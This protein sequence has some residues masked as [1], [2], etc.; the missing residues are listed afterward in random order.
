MA[1]RHSFHYNTAPSIQ[2]VYRLS[3]VIEAVCHPLPLFPLSQVIKV[4]VLAVEP[5]TGRL[6]L[7]LASSK[8]ASAAVS[9]AASEGDPY[10]GLEAGNLAEAV[11]KQ[12]RGGGQMG[13]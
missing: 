6:K 5:A 2:L 3:G 11:I 1:S 13:V 8:K 7:G 12:V 9:E 10:A 4:C